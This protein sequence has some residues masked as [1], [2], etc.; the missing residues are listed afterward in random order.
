MAGSPVTM[1]AVQNALNGLIPCEGPKALCYAA[2]FSVAT[3]YDFD[4][5]QQF[6]QNI[7]TMLQC[8][9]IDN[10]DNSSVV[11]VTVNG[12]GQTFQAPANSCG[13]YTLLM[14]SP[15]KLVLASQGG[16]VVNVQLLNFYIPPT[17]WLVA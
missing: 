13:F 14:T 8:I 12:T 10:S 16:V 4:L 7:F 1:L 17:V 9:F 2:D 6:Q 5:T 11:E 3:E 15:P